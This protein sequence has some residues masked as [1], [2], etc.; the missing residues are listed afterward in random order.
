[1]MAAAL[2]PGSSI[3]RS[4]AAEVAVSAS[5]EALPPRS[6]GSVRVIWSP[7]SEVLPH[8]NIRSMSPQRT[9]SEPVVRPADLDD[10][11]VALLDAV[12]AI[13]P[14]AGHGDP[15]AP[16]APGAGLT[17]R[18]LDTLFEDRKSVV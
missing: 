8:C 3:R 1:M 12:A 15:A 11:T 10:D 4:G 7:R 2:G 9:E 18:D 6:V 14:A 16:L 17:G 13:E 5:S